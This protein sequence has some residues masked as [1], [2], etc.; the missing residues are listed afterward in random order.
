[1]RPRTTRLVA[2]AA[3]AALA[4]VALTGCAPRGS[5]DGCVP[6]ATSGSASDAVTA[7]G[8][9]GVAPTVRFSAPLHSTATQV[10]STIAGRGAP[11]GSAQQVVADLTLL[12]GTTG[13]VVTRSDYAGLTSAATFVVG[14]VGIPGL[15]KAL[16]CSRVGERLAAVIPPSQ[17]IPAANRPQGL[18]AADSLVAVIDVRRAYLARADGADQVMGSGLP[19]VVL[20]SDGRP[21]IT[22][23]EGAPPKTLRVANLK[24]GSGPV[25]KRG[26]NAIVQYTGVLWNPGDAGTGT[27]FDSSWRNGAPVVLPVKNGQIVK[28]LVTAL[29]GQRVGSQVLAVLP[30]SQAYGSQSSSSVPANSTLVFVVDVLGTS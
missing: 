25:V 4:A 14:K 2:G 15:T 16:V 9:F 18:G 5:I 30:P 23:P 20:G 12:N 28:G 11:I 22:L 17:S 27:V 3:A 29:A 26:A 19:A 6:S 21:G 8:R 24:K 7:T 13:K 1:M 10:T